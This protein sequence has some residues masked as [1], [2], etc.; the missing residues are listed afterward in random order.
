MADLIV[1]VHAQRHYLIRIAMLQLRDRGAAEDVVQET[2]LAALESQ[3]GF[4]GKSSVR[5]W[6]MGILRHRI[7]DAIRKR[8]NEPLLSSSTAAA[9]AADGV[10]DDLDVF[11]NADDRDRWETRPSE[12]RNPERDFEQQDFIGV[13]ERCLEKLPLKAARVFMLRE[14]M[15]METDEICQELKITPTNVWVILYRARMLLR[16]CLEQTW[17]ADPARSSA[18]R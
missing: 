4:A 18:S 10:V 15:D 1:E 12:W 2:L 17:F 9:E 11:F 8:S 6:V 16:Q 7:V 14:V 5:T 3:D 13:L